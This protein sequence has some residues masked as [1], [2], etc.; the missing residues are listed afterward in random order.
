MNVYIE[1]VT[2]EVRKGGEKVR[3]NVKRKG[4]RKEG[5]GDKCKET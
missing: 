4:G 1:G 5:M 3:K 2:C